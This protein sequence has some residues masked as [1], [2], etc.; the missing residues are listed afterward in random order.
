[1]PKQPFCATIAPVAHAKKYRAASRQ[2]S[3]IRLRKGNFPCTP[4]IPR[5]ESNSA[6]VAVVCPRRLPLRQTPSAAMQKANHP[7]SLLDT[8][9]KWVLGVPAKTAFGKRLTNAVQMSVGNGKPEKTEAGMDCSITV[10]LT[11]FRTNCITA[12]FPKGLIVSINATI[13]LA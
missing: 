6:N 3:R 13:R 11:A 1:M 9:L 12:P 5:M 10:S 4:I 2:R 8:G 7:A